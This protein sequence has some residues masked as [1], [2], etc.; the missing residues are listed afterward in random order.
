MPEKELNL[1]YFDDV[2]IEP[3]VT[4]DKP[5]Q[6][7]GDDD[8]NNDYDPTEVN[9]NKTS[10]HG[11]GGRRREIKATTRSLEKSND[12]I[13]ARAQLERREK[14]QKLL[15]NLL[16]EIEKRAKDEPT[17]EKLRRV[18]FN[19]CNRIREGGE[20][21]VDNELE[22]YFI[23]SQGAG[24][25]NVQ[26]VN[27]QAVIIHLPTQISVRSQELLFALRPYVNATSITDE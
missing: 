21:I 11:G 7:W 3:E 23:R 19:W 9:R 22:E 25:Q 27:S 14:A 24:G 5:F 12:G 4:D 13:R 17:R 2:P 20:I 16:A 8:P 10:R 6:M 26:K 18:F 15:A 1:E